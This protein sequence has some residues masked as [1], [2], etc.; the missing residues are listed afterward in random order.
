MKKK[1][2]GWNI[3]QLILFT[4]DFDF[5]KSTSGYN[6]KNKIQLNRKSK[7]KTYSKCYHFSQNN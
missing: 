1:N 5:K 7:L 6:L 3:I 2:N 4:N